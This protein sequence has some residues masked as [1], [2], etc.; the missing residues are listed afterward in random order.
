[1]TE[2]DIQGQI[3]TFND[4]I[5]SM[6]ATVVKLIIKIT[7]AFSHCQIKLTVNIYLVALLKLQDEV[8][9]QLVTTIEEAVK[10]DKV[11]SDNNVV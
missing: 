5:K 10:K 11:N 3:K 6:I 9:I 1:M 2:T 7:S 8:T 4:C